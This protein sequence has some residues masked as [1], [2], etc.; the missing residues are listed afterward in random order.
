MRAKDLQLIAEMFP[1]STFEAHDG[2]YIYDKNG[3]CYVCILTTGFLSRWIIRLKM[4]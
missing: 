4:K 1:K 3:R 2:L